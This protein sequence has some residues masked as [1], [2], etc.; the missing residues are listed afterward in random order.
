[1][2]GGL[3]FL[4]SHFPFPGRITIFWLKF[5]K[6][7]GKKRVQCINGYYKLCRQNKARNLYLS[8][9]LP[10]AYLLFVY[11]YFENELKFATAIINYATL[12][13]EKAAKIVILPLDHESNSQ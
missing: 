4:D 13:T 6:L 5:I 11:S 7:F 12:N 8:A 3:Q 9:H 2:K 10:K 1:M